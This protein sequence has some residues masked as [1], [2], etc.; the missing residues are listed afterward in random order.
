MQDQRERFRWVGIGVCVAVLGVVFALVGT[1]AGQPWTL[2]GVGTF[3]VGWIIGGIAA[4]K[5]G[6]RFGRGEQ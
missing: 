6:Y 2:V 4:V 5:A 3:V 1:F